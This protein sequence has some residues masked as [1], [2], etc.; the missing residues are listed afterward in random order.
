MKTT[1]EG[2]RIKIETAGN[3][4]NAKTALKR[5]HK[6]NGKLE[7]VF[8]RIKYVGMN[9]KKIQHVCNWVFWKTKEK[10]IWSSGGV[11]TSRIKMW[12]KKKAKLPRRKKIHWPH[13]S[14]NNYFQWQNT[15][16]K[17]VDDS[18]KKKTWDSKY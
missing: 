12:E 8:E 14:P 3:R 13:N 9:I 5:S 6:Q 11:G 16:E 10:N 15:V 18:E 1:L 7:K 17:Y 4:F 2:A